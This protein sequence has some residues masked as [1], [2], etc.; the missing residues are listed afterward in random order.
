MRRRRRSLWPWIAT[1]A[2]LSAIGTAAYVL[3][4]NRGTPPPAERSLATAASAAALRE[5]GDAA[6][7]ASA[8][9]TALAPPNSSGREQIVDDPQGELLWASPT[10]GP[11][12]DLTYMPLGAQCLVHL[13][14]AELAAHP[15]GERVL[16]ALGPWGAAAVARLQSLAG[17][18]LTEIDA[19]LA[20]VMVAPGERLDAVLRL[21]LKQSPTAEQLAERLQGAETREHVGRTYRV[22][23]ERA[24]AIVEVTD[25]AAPSAKVQRQLLIAPAGVME[26]LLAAGGE[27]PALVRDV[28]ALI[29]H[30]DRVRAATVVVAPK[31]LE[32]SGSELLVADAAPLREALA[33]FTGSDVAAVA[34]SAHWDDNF[35]VEVRAVPTLNVSPHR[36]A[37]KLRERLAAA[38]EAIEEVIL[39]TPWHPYG[40]RVLARFPG[41]LRTAAR[42]A[43]SGADDRQA[44]VRC[45]LPAVAGHNLAMGAELLLTLPRSDMADSSPSIPA[46]PATLEE[47]LATRTSLSFTK[48]TLQRAIELLAEDTGIEIVIQGA[49]LQ[50]EGITKNQSFGIDL[51]NQPASVILVAILQ[52]ANP[53]RTA[54]DAADPR[55]K[56]VYL[57]QPG[58]NGA[59]GR[60]IVTTR[61]AAAKR[62]D[63]LADPFV[64]MKR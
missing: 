11:R 32:A 59:A 35:F 49:D 10:A 3:L 6:P 60:I 30:A 63:R 5:P 48:D 9:N 51:R 24:Y 56:L 29:P 47:R 55:Q 4:G 33:W 17:A 41:M 61:A 38:P 7:N 52:R 62:G 50:L 40:R 27:S 8:T 12:I 16:A 23:N 19:V 34:L 25:L 54:A 21:T 31:F 39:A 20:A 57:V 18:E 43:R 45:Y 26:E 42:Y 36:L 58:Q 28:D 22:L 64:G 15:E 37:V 44:V 14:P 13:R 53:D 1:A 2:G 46:R